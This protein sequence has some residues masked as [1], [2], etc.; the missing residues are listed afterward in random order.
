[1]HGAG[2]GASRRAGAV[3]AAV[4]LVTFLV[5]MVRPSPARAGAQGSQDLSIADALARAAETGQPVLASGASTPTTSTTANPDGSLSSTIASGP[6]QEPDSSSPTGWSLLDLTLQHLDGVY[7]PVRSA[8]T[9]A[10]SDGTP[11]PLATMGVG[12]GSYAESWQGPLPAPEVSGDTAT[13]AAIMP[14]VDLVLQAKAS[15]FEERFVV[16]AAPQQPIVIDLPLTLSALNASVDPTGALVLSDAQGNQVA[17]SGTPVMY[18]AATDENGE[19]TA[20]KTVATSI[21]QGRDGPVLQIEPDPAFFTEPGATYPVTVDPSTDLGV[22][23]DTYVK[24]SAPTSTFSTNNDLKIGTPDGSDVLRSLISFGDVAGTLG[25]GAVVSSATLNLYETDSGSCTASEV[26]V[27]DASSSWDSS[28]T[29]NTQPSAGTLWS[30]GSFAKGFSGSCAAGWTALSSGGSGGFTLTD[31]VQD[32]ADADADNGVLIKASSES[33]TAGWKRFSASDSGVHVPYL[34]TTYTSPEYRYGSGFWYDTSHDDTAESNSATLVTDV[35]DSITN[36]YI[37]L[38]GDDSDGSAFGVPNYWFSKGDAPNSETIYCQTYP[39]PCPG[40]PSETDWLTFTLTYFNPDTALPSDDLDSQVEIKDI[41]PDQSGP[42]VWFH[43]F[44]PPAGTY[45]NPWCDDHAVADKWTADQMT[46]DQF[47]SDGMDGCW[48]NHYSYTDDTFHSYDASNEGDVGTPAA[49]TSIRAWELSLDGINPNNKLKHS[50]VIHLPD[51]S[52]DNYFPLAG[53]NG[54]TTGGIPEGMILYLNSDVSAPEGA[55]DALTYIIDALKTYGA[56]VGTT[57]TNPHE[58]AAEIDLEDL[59]VDDWFHGSDW[60]DLGIARGSLSSI[61]LDS[62]NFHFSAGG[63]DGPS[64][65]EWESEGGDCE[66]LSPP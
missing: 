22:D 34:A 36:D 27:Y 9:T 65:S 23:V 44:C 25:T 66:S 54:T 13:Y 50:L 33:S 2:A 58:N 18:G 60:S 41:K 56:V 53:S 17:T 59:Q 4:A 3:L 24:Q 37:Q 64:A 19:P 8:T 16:T 62:S 51:T 52:S 47:L 10:F 30:S 38:A 39:T 7:S 31:L 6:V 29:W 32:W 61:A 46:D 15:G 5:T 49:F 48:Y 42:E 63:V 55:S 43:H 35:K 20:S 14:N 26:D 57:D 21:V 11:G 45:S 12:T 1:M 28:V 40:F